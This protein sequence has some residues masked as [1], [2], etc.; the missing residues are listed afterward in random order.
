MPYIVIDGNSLAYAEVAGCGS[1]NAGV[2]GF[3]NAVKRYYSIY[4]DC[5]PIVLWDGKS[6]YRLSI[7]P[8]YKAH[9]RADDTLRATVN[10]A[11][12]IIKQLLQHLGICQMRNPEAEA[13][14]LAYYI[15]KKLISK[16]DGAVLITGDRDWLQLV[17]GYDISWRSHR[18]DEIINTT[19]LA[20]LVFEGISI[21]SPQMLVE[22]KALIGDDSDNIPGVGGIGSKAA[23]KIFNEW[24]SVENLERI[25]DSGEMPAGKAPGVVGSYLRNEAPQLSL[26]WGERLPRRE[27]FRR[28]LKLID[29]SLA[30][31]DH[32]LTEVDRGEENA[33]EY[34]DLCKRHNLMQLIKS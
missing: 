17:H 21:N 33:N 22:Y 11:N 32:R 29:L 5:I 13:D 10:V 28:N 2:I 27:A 31:V 14:D 23:A 30:E 16:G 9:R 15:S 8:Q 3:I 25:Y 34:Y 20:D 1:V 18:N 4:K 12:A 19:N 26:K 6:K 24:G 7:Y